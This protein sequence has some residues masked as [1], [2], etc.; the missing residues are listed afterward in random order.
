MSQLVWNADCSQN[1]RG[2]SSKHW[3]S[4]SRQQQSSKRKAYARNIKAAV[5]C[6]ESHF[7][8]EIENIDTGNREIIDLESGSFSSK[9]VDHQISDRTKIQFAL[10]VKDKFSLSDE[11]YHEMTMLTQDL[12]RSSQVKAL[13]K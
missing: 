6:C 13:K 10:Y 4:Y 9:P 1:K 7:K 3:N 12:P 5:S 11:A 8:P 2:S